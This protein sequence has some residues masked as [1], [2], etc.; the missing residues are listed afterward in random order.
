MR[1]SDVDPGR[2]SAPPVEARIIFEGLLP[3]QG[4]QVQRVELRR[5]AQQELPAREGNELGEARQEVSLITAVVETDRGTAEMKYIEGVGGKDL[6][7]TAEK[8]LKGYSG[9]SSLVNRALLE[10]VSAS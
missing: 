10:L 8:M 6:I 9:L 7:D 2:I 4:F 3:L 5:Y 1:V